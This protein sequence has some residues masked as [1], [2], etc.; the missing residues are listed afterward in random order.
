M[1]G[2]ELARNSTVVSISFHG[3]SSMSSMI[4][5][6]SSHFLSA[7]AEGGLIHPFVVGSDERSLDSTTSTQSDPPQLK[8]P[9]D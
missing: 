5:L 7:D 3:V 1:V 4:V 2:K 8:A 9:V 6:L